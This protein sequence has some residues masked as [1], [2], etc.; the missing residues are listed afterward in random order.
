[1]S[2]NRVLA[3]RI[4]AEF[5]VFLERYLDWLDRVDAAEIAA[6]ARVR[7]AGGRV[8][9]CERVGRDDGLLELVFRDVAT[10]DLLGREIYDPDGRMLSL[11]HLHS[12]DRDVRSVSAELPACDVPDPF[13]FTMWINTYLVDDIRTE[14][15]S[16]LAKLSRR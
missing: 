13:G 14:F 11:V 10:G 16:I 12:A 3:Q 8:Y 6:H 15:E 9:S 4:S 7:A 1:M 5:V 2:D